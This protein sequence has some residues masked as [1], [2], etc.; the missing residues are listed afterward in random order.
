[1]TQK[2]IWDLKHFDYA[3]FRAE[4]IQKQNETSFQKCVQQAERIK[5]A[6]WERYKRQ[7]ERDNGVPYVRA[8]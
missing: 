1:M 6:K 2:P 7:Y 5:A 3:A 4:F 8:N